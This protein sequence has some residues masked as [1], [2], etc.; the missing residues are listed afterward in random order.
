MTFI[1]YSY[2]ICCQYGYEGGASVPEVGVI[3]AEQPMGYDKQQVDN[4]IAKIT[5]EYQN[6]HNEYMTLVSRN[7][8]LTAQ[9]TEERNRTSDRPAPIH[10]HN[11]QQA[12]PLGQS[13]LNQSSQNS[14]SAERDA[15][16]RALIDA[17]MLAKQIVDK[18][19][20]EESKAVKSVNTARDELKQIQLWKDKAMVEVQD[21]RKKINAFFPD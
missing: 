18:A 14:S 10:G 6:L 13:P 12:N 9:L 20:E 3:F 21:I 2:T 16:A 11:G 17:E 5:Y 19:R 4:Y 15:I 7:A 8:S 1:C